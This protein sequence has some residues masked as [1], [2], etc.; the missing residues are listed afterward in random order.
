[1]GYNLTEC[2]S[3]IIF[4]R[5]YM[6]TVDIL[7][8]VSRSSYICSMYQWKDSITILCKNTGTPFIGKATMP[9]RGSKNHYVVE[10]VKRTAECTENQSMY[11]ATPSQLAVYKF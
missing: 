6:V 9:K 2:L 10:I 3:T 5:S 11:L 4:V 7:E 1:M 8:V